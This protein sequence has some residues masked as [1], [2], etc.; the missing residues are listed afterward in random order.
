MRCYGFFSNCIFFQKHSISFF[1]CGSAS[2]CRNELVLLKTRS[3]ARCYCGRIPGGD[4]CKILQSS[5]FQ[6]LHSNLRKVLFFK[7]II[8][9]IL[10][11]LDFM[12]H[13]LNK[14]LTL[15]VIICFQVGGRVVRTP[16]PPP[17]PCLR[18]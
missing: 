1:K 6:A 2:F 5:N 11:I 14:T 8:L 3:G 15:I 18:V 16:R 4:W 13:S 17:T 10:K 12:S 7:K 9:Y